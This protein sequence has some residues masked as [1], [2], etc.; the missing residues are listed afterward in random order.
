MAGRL[1]L[2]VRPGQVAPVL[3]REYM[4]RAAVWAQAYSAETAW[5][6]FDI[7]SYVDPAFRLPPEAEA[8]L[9]ELLVR[10][11]TWR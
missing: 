11:P 10:L 4:R 9:A 6:F 3:F 1:G 5:P 8:E 2:R 7:T